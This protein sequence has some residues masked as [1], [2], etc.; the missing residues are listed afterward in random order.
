MAVTG[1]ITPVLQKV[2]KIKHRLSAFLYVLEHVS[3][4]VENKRKISPALYICSEYC[5]H[6]RPL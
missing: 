4:E 6:I 1:I 2:K 3:C 5:K